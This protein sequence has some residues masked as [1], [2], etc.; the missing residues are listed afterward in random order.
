MAFNDAKGPLQ[1]LHLQLGE[2]GADRLS[3][4]WISFL[5]WVHPELC[6]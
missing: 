1:P 2:R 6:K 3:F 4:A 5:S